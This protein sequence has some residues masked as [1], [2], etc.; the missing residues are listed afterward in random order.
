[1]SRRDEGASGEI[2]RHER[3]ALKGRGHVVESGR[4]R[5]TSIPYTIKAE[6]GSDGRDDL[7]D[8]LVQACEARLRDIEAMLA[9][10]VSCIA[11]KAGEPHAASSFSFQALRA[12]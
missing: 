8:Q 1:M 2:T 7:R 11:L 6:R 4:I 10:I 9:D 5:H 3:W 12:C